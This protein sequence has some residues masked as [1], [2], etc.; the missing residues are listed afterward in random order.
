MKGQVQLTADGARL[1]FIGFP[2]ETYTI[3]AS[4]D[5]AHWVTLGTTTATADGAV[6]FDDRDSARY[7]SR[8]YRIVMP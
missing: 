8:F 6:Q 1:R 3:Q 4:T 2:G 5:L 7:P